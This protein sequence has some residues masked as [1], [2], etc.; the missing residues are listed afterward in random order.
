MILQIEPII[1][2]IKKGSPDIVNNIKFESVDV[3]KY[4]QRAYQD[5][6]VTT[7]Y[8]FQFTFRKYYNLEE[9][10]LSHQFH[11]EYFR[12][13]QDLKSNREAWNYENVI[14][15]LYEIPRA[16][17]DKSVQCSFVS[18]M[19]HTNDPA[20]VVYDSKVAKMFNFSNLN[21]IPFDQ[22][23]QHFKNRIG[24]IS[25]NYKKIIDHGLL[26]E[27]CESFDTRFENHGLHPT[28]KLDFIFWS[29]GKIIYSRTK[30]YL[31]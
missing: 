11:L 4:L 3:Y 16:K 20:N 5:T 31:E 10:R 18:K 1:K 26:S 7:N 29:A 17:G 25:Y 14:E 9:A 6:D 30:D 12:I 28:K 15:K 2:L 27:V 13:L 21:L 22:K 19:F 8:M 24:T 23:I